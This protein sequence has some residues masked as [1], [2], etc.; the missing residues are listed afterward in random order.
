MFEV[1]PRLYLANGRRILSRASN[2][3]DRASEVPI[4][5]DYIATML[6]FLVVALFASGACYSLVRILRALL[7]G[8]NG[9][10]LHDL[11]PSEAAEFGK[12]DASESMTS[13][14]VRPPGRPASAV[15]GRGVSSS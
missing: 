14:T 8:T 2:R 5:G 15:R 9:A 7:Y 1:G 10:P 13:V 11:Q 3:I 6:G 4:L 12:D